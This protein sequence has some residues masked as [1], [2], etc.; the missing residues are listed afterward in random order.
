MNTLPDSPR[1][2]DDIKNEKG[3]HQEVEDVALETS[4][5][6]DVKDT[7]KGTVGLT[8]ESGAVVLIPTPSADPSGRQGERNVV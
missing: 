3:Y 7:I 6:L 1:L 5:E 4:P 8:S 2:D